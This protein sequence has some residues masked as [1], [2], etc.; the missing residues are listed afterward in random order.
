MK[1]EVLVIRAPWLLAANFLGA[2]YHCRPAL[3]RCTRE[4]QIRLTTDIRLRFEAKQV[5]IKFA[6][7]KYPDRNNE[8]PTMTR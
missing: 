6:C 8:I 5:F 2:H 7:D 1:T 4:G 3:P